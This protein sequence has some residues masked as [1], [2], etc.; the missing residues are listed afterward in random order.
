MLILH[1][2]SHLLKAYAA[3]VVVISVPGQDSSA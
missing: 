1:S 2:M 3:A